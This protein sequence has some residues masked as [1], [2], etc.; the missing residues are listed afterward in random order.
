MCEAGDELF[1]RVILQS[2][3]ALNPWAVVSKPD[4]Y[5]R[6]FFT[7]S[8]AMFNCTQLITHPHPQ[9]QQQQQQ[10]VD[11]L[12]QVPVDRLIHVN[13]HTLSYMSTLGPVVNVGDLLT[14]NVRHLMMLKESTAPWSRTSLLLGFVSNEGMLPGHQYRQTIMWFIIPTSVTLQYL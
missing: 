4:I 10:V 5:I 11:C 1:H 14:S 9:T 2:G 6:Q 12:R 3:S 8:T 7:E 13:M